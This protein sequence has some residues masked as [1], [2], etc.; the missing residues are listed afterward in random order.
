MNS[1]ITYIIRDDDTGEIIAECTGTKQEARDMFRG[2]AEAK[3]LLGQDDGHT[4]SLY[5]R[6]SL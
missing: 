6:V 5:E 2:M 3:E 4:W 1:L